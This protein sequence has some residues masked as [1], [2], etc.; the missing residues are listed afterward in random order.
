MRNT[1]EKLLQNQ[2]DNYI[3]PFFWQRGE[4]EETIRHYMKIIRES[5]I[6]AVCVESRPHPDFCG[7]KWWADMDVILEEARQRDMRVWILDDSHF[8]TGYANGALENQPPE[9]HRQSVICTRVPVKGKKIKLKLDK[10]IHPKHKKTLVEHGVGILNKQDVSFRQHTDDRLL[11]LSAWRKDK[12]QDPLDLT[13]LIKDGV[14]LWEAPA[15]EWEI[16]VCS[17]SRNLGPHR[18]YINMMDEASCRLLI[19]AVYEPH[20]QHYGEHFGKTIA[21]FFSDEPELGNG[22]LYAVG[23]VLGTEQDLPWSAPLEQRLQAGL[24][25]DNWLYLP[26]LW[27]DDQREDVTAR[28]RYQYMDA[29]TRLVEHCFSQQLG[30]W[31]EAHGLD[32]IGHVIED[33]NQ[34]ARMGSSLGHYFRALSGQ[35]MA[36]IDD[37]GGQVLP[38][39]ED[40]KK[41]NLLH[42]RDGEFYHFALGKLASSLAAIDPKKQGRAMCEIFGNYGWSEGMKLENYLANHFLVR[43]VNYYVPHAFSM[44]PY[45]DRDCP[46]H[47]YAHGNNPQYRHFGAL[48]LYTNR[49]CALLSGG[50]HVA[51]IAVLYHGE[52]EWTGDCML[53]QKP[54]R[55]LAERQ[56]EFDFIPSDVFAETER[57]QTRLDESLRVHTQTYRAL[58][59]PY[60]Q[61]IAKELADAVCAL[62]NHGFP[63]FFVD[64]LPEG[65]YNDEI[66][67]AENLRGL[68][69]LPLDQLIAKLETLSIPE[70]RITPENKHIRY[71][72]YQNNGDLYLFVN[73]SDALYTGSITL[74]LPGPCYAYNAWENHPEALRYQEENGATT[75][76][77]ELT[78][79]K[80]LIVVFGEA[81]KA[82][83]EPLIVSGECVDFSGQWSRSIC[84]SIEYP[85]FV[86]E[87]TVELPDNLAEEQ[88]KFSG[89]ARYTN[90]FTAAEGATY[91]LEVTQAYEGVEVFVNGRSAGI[92]IAEPFLYDISLLVR[93]GE[94]TLQIE[95]AST[96]ERERYYGGTVGKLLAKKPVCPTGIT[97]AVTLWRDVTE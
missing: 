72:H 63:V 31:C 56:I 16:C 13:G 66:N 93:K 27:D 78:P 30:S 55:L 77:V 61:F 7:P 19:D 79:R 88:P 10:Y 17:L 5:N 96:L 3:L 85:N 75:L 23:N 2:E 34:H 15:G 48:M 91:L 67:N 53:M 33:N 42:E 60:A 40:L 90:S 83:R 84:R 12:Q 11:G 24:G 41:K 1:I 81:P 37:I 76:T 68:P 64:A 28:V 50:V 43:G 95:V 49:V 14:L 8:P 25:Q 71:Y 87:K 45:P 73:E 58:V 44:K 36:G 32:Y 86:D 94:N 26:L 97:G 39:G 59:I 62:H 21:G 69:V 92:Q 38:Q 51:P 47:F 57:Y 18:N 89:F 9:L 22:H 20:Y 35:H 54:A 82:L 6:R 46:P 29:V 70:V 80:S 74:P 65:C 4:S 52:A